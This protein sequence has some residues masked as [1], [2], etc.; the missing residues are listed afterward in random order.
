M[1]ANQP[2]E[3][4]MCYILSGLRHSFG[5]HEEL[6]SSS[7][8]FNSSSSRKKRI[9]KKLPPSAVPLNTQTHI[10]INTHIHIQTEVTVVKKNIQK[11]CPFFVSFK[12]R[13]H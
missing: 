3:S 7:V 13:M 8:W 1:T 4:V 10:Q 12:L 9:N 6:L 11:N 2:P 5:P